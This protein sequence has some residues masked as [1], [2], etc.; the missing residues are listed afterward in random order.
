MGPARIYPW[1]KMR[2]S[3][4]PS[5]APDTFFV[6]QSWA[7]CTTNMAGFNFRQPQGPHAIRHAFGAILKKKHV[8]EELRA[9]LLGHAGKSETSERY[10]E[11]TEIA[12]MYKLLC[13]MPVAA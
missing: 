9:D 5:S 8:R 3:R 10:C 11:P 12:A 7:D 2:Q 1:R 6:A 4:A 13:K